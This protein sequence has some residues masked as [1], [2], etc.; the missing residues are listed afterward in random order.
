VPKR[1]E[2]GVENL[3]RNMSLSSVMVGNIE[4]FVATNVEEL[5]EFDSSKAAVEL[6]QLLTIYNRRVDEVEFDKSL[7]VEI[8][9]NLQKL[10]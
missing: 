6:A 4:T 1:I 8:P 3:L 5:S 10:L 7:M 9:Q 2:L